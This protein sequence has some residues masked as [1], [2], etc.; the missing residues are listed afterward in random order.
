MTRRLI[1]ALFSA[2]LVLALAAGLAIVLQPRDEG[3]IDV[4]GTTDEGGPGEAEPGD[5]KVPV[6][7]PER[8]GDGPDGA[9]TP[10]PPGGDEA[11]EPSP[12]PGE[13][14][15]TLQDRRG[16]PVNWGDLLVLD[17]AERAVP[18]L[19]RG[20]DGVWRTG[21][22]APGIY[23]IRYSRGPGSPSF[24][25]QAFKI[26]QGESLSLT[27][28]ILQWDLEGRALD[29]ESSR[30][31]AGARIFI[32]KERGEEDMM[33]VGSPTGSD[34]F[35]SLRG[36]PVDRCHVVVRAPGYGLESGTFSADRE[37]VSPVELRMDRSAGIVVEFDPPQDV[38]ADEI[39]IVVQGGEF[40][41]P[42][43]PLA[44]TADGLPLLD[45]SPGEYRVTFKAVGHFRTTI[46]IE[47]ED[48]EKGTV[49][50]P[51]KPR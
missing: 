47:P 44:T 50:V 18:S 14:W 19:A 33:P 36:L 43:V 15:I 3:E 21:P 27:C 13:V 26:S 23:T 20:Q 30:P 37:S 24:R 45:L 12:G 10:D 9:G 1:T 22:V 2:L 49:R 4:S 38:P 11:E 5:S 29:D 35:F 51:V 8:K 25:I 16:S 31:L 34:G 40:R 28:G 32:G 42:T 48:F 39:G 17:G 41:V 6:E 46:R 7:L